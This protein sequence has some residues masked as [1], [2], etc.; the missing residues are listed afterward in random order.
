MQVRRYWARNIR[1]I[2]LPVIEVSYE[3]EDLGTL[4][5]HVL[6][7]EARWLNRWAVLEFVITN[8]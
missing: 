4:K 8:K 7:L 2:I 1:W 5:L 6:A 3:K